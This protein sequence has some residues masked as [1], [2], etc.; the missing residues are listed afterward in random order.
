MPVSVVAVK[1]GSPNARPPVYSRGAR[2]LHVFVFDRDGNKRLTANRTDRE[3]NPDPLLML[4]YISFI[5]LTYEFC[6]APATNQPGQLFKRQRGENGA[7]AKEL[8]DRDGVTKW[9]CV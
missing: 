6:F 5:L 7:A 3:K 4:C 1:T 9:N 8:R 2:V